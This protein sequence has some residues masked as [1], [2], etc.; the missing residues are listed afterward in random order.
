M[1]KDSTLRV[2]EEKVEKK[3]KMV[4][5]KFFPDLPNYACESFEKW[6]EHLEIFLSKKCIKPINKFVVDKSLVF[7]VCEDIYSSTN[8]GLENKDELLL[9]NTK[10]KLV[11]NANRKLLIDMVIISLF[12]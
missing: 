6:L 3:L 9:Q 4:L 5:L 11:I 7:N 10:L 8:D 2:S 1:T 12:T